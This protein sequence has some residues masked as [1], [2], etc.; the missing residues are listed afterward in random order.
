MNNITVDGS[1]FEKK[2]F[3]GLTFHDDTLNVNDFHDVDN[4]HKDFAALKNLDEFVQYNCVQQLKK[5]ELM[6]EFSSI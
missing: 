6:N 1:V 4:I 5:F 2:D 3:A